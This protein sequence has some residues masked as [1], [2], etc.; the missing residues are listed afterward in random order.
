[1][2]KGSLLQRLEAQCSWVKTPSGRYSN[3]VKRIV[4]QFVASEELNWGEVSRE[5]GMDYSSVIEWPRQLKHR[6]RH[7]KIIRFSESEKI[8]IV[9]E[10]ESGS[11]SI[12]QVADR[13]AIHPSN[14]RR[15]QKQYSLQFYPQPS[16]AK[17]MADQASEENKES[18]EL[19]ERVR[20]LEKAL[21]EEKLKVEALQTM[22]KVAEQ[23]LNIGIRKKF[24]TKQSE[25]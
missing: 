18:A 19:Q 6:A 13:Y 9:R 10:L 23:E 1:M 17:P 11:L 7:G 20:L 16:I 3:E 21:F 14:I 12:T 22:I 4:C 15:W 5:L 25:S 24:G 8:N 2:E